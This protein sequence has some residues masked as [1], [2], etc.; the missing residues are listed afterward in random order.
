MQEQSDTESSFKVMIDQDSYRTH[1]QRS[2]AR[3]KSRNARARHLLSSEVKPSVAS[4]NPNSLA[5][6]NRDHNNTFPPPRPRA[7]VS[8]FPDANLATRPSFRDNGVSSYNPARPL[9]NSYPAARAPNL[10][11]SLRRPAPAPAMPRR[12]AMGNTSQTSRSSRSSGSSRSSRSSKSHRR[13]R[14]RRRRESTNAWRPRRER[15]KD[16][17]GITD[18]SGSSSFDEDSDSSG[19]ELNALQKKIVYRTLQEYLPESVQHVAYE[20]VISRM[21]Q[22]DK[23]GY[24]LPK[25]YDARKHNLAENE[26]KLYEQQFMRNKSRDQK[27]M[28]HILNFSALGLS[29]FCK[30]INVDFIKTSKLPEIMRVSLE[31]GEWDECLDG[32]GTHLRGT[33][34]DNPIFSTAL[35]FFE[36]IGEAHHMETE[37]EQDRLEEE[38]DRK[39]V[40]HAQHLRNLNMMRNNAGGPKPFANVPPPPAP[41]Q[42]P[43]APPQVARAV[44]STG[45]KGKKTFKPV[46]Q[47]KVPGNLGSMFSQLQAPLKQL[48][49]MMNVDDQVDQEDMA[50]AGQFHQ[51]KA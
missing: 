21:E 12:W 47:S 45:K 26:I 37:E 5:F 29:W 38:E 11:D 7:A 39:A 16:K 30:F 43:A 2:S 14:R 50:A 36:K 19:D 1:K 51:L 24:K 23:Q 28:A 17:Y 6:M 32:I 9:T 25:G 22:M 40:K 42:T 48:T 34:A 4:R 31:E 35:K 46:A 18:E 33:V 27:K 8:Q 41:A 20:D 49:S 10:L 3:Q 15:R 13:P 44:P